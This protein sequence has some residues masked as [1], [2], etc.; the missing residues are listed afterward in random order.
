[1]DPKF[2]YLYIILLSSEDFILT[3]TNDID[4]IKQLKE[5]DPSYLIYDCSTGILEI[6]P[7][8]ETTGGEIKE[9]RNETLY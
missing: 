5:Q 4:K 2:R 7:L 8:A 6:G 3:G 9:I 1:M